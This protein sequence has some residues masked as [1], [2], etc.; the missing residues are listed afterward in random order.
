MFKQTKSYLT[1]ERNKVVKGLVRHR[2]IL[3]N[4]QGDDWCSAY[5]ASER[6][7]EQLSK[8]VTTFGNRQ[9]ELIDA[10]REIKRLKD[11]VAFW[12]EK[13]K[14]YE[15]GVLWLWRKMND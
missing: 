14:E 3:E 1:R 7:V 15:S 8:E 13:A 9:K 5:S 12:S 11:E 6:K 2:E 10:E 4:W